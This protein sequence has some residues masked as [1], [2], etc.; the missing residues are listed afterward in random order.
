MKQESNHH[1]I[2]YARFKEEKMKRGGKKKREEKPK[3]NAKELFPKLQQL[4]CP[5]DASG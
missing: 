4:K 3:K 1:L 5:F 2:R